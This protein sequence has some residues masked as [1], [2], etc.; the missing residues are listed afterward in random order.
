MK[1]NFKKL[2]SNSTLLQQTFAKTES[3]YHDLTV[4]QKPAGSPLSLTA[5]HHQSLHK[6]PSPSGHQQAEGLGRATGSQG[7]PDP[8]AK[9]VV[10]SLSLEDGTGAEVRF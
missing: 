7:N 3:S 9:K 6:H 4:P 10:L 8:I 5:R 2:K 1:N